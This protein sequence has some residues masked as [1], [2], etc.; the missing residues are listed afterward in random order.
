M[1]D[2]LSNYGLFLAK[3][4]TVVIAI[5]FVIGMIANVAAKQK[6]RKGELQVENLS[7]KIRETRLQLEQ[8]LLSGK[9]LKEAQKRAKKE[10]KEHKPKDKRLFVLD[11]KGS[12]DAREVASLRREVTAILQIAKPEDEVL[13]RL[14]SG[15]GVVHGYGLAAAQLKRIK[16]KGIQL[17]VA[18]DK[19]AASGGYMMACIADRLVA[20]P[21]AVVGSIGVIAQLP[22]FNKLLKKNNIEFEQVTAGEYKRTLTIFGE[23]TEQGRKKFKEEIEVI[24]QMFKDFVKDNRADLDIDAVA[25]GE[26]W[27]GQKA[28]EKGL[29]DELSTSDDLL[30]V[31]LEDKELVK[32]HYKPKPKLGEKL[33]E[34]AQGAIEKAT[35]DWV[36]KSRFWTQ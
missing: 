33:A 17:T 18:V 5:G 11:F 23:N 22:N 19:V 35:G 27:Y 29:V 34:R 10:S 9:A 30:L 24:H 25:T 7:D 4:I 20:A 16:A 1:A 36:Q 14:E 3:I 6:D 21:F 31:A 2:L 26:V 12:M 8:G 13:V 28:L 15:G 32:V